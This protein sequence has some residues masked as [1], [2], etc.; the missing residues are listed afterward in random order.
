MP[1]G[2]IKAQAGNLKKLLPLLFRDVVNQTTA[3]Y[4]FGERELGLSQA[5]AQRDIIRVQDSAFKAA[6]AWLCL[7]EVMHYVLDAVHHHQPW[8]PKE[9]VDALTNETSDD[10]TAV[11]QNSLTAVNNALVIPVARHMLQPPYTRNFLEF[12]H[13]FEAIQPLRQA[14]DEAVWKRL[15]PNSDK[16]P[17]DSQIPIPKSLRAGKRVLAETLRRDR[18]EEMDAWKENGL[19]IHPLQ[20]TVGSTTRIVTK[21]IDSRRRNAKSTA[22]DDAINPLFLEQISQLARMSSQ[23][24]TSQMREGTRSRS[25]FTIAPNGDPTYNFPNLLNNS[26][27]I[28]GGV[29]EFPVNTFALKEFD[30]LVGRSSEVGSDRICSNAVHLHLL[31]LAL[32]TYVPEKIRALS[33][34]PAELEPAKDFARGIESTCPFAQ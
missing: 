30:Q 32:R 14:A 22:I 7:R 31:G 21:L 23:A 9:T 24:W 25:M 15:L 13:E 27:G 26:P 8:L 4:P 16:V 17:I 3:E 19:A 10:A 18:W 33:F 5:L 12:M 28:C 6:F 2:H 20:V 34:T 1:Y 29:I 11:L